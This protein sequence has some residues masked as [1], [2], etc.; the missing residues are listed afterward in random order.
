MLRRMSLAT[1]GRN[2]DMLHEVQLIVEAAR[3]RDGPA[4]KAACV[5]HVKSAMNA[6]IS[7]L[8]STRSD[9]EN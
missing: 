6:T 9:Q 5:A 7:Q 4:M 8:S 3:A 1:V 2:A